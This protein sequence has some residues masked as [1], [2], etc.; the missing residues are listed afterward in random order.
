[1][2]ALG[3]YMLR[4]LAQLLPVA[5]VIVMS[6]YVLLRMAPGDMVDV[7]AGESGAA[8]PEYMAQLRQQFDLDAPGY[9][10]FGR[11]LNNLAHLDLGYSFRNS[12]PVAELIAQRVPATLTLMLVAVAIAALLG[13]TLGAVSAR[14]RGRWLDEVISTL[15]TIGFATPVFWVGLLLI[16]VFS[17]NL[18]WLPSAGMQT[19]GGVDGFWA[20]LLD[21]LRYMALPALSLSFFYLSIY[22]RMTRSAMLEVYGLDFI[23]TARAKGI[24]E[25]R[26][27]VR[28]VLRNALLPLVTITGLQLGSLMGGSIVVETVFSW[29]GLGR[30]AF[31]AVFQ[32]DINLL[33]GIFLCSSFLVIL[34]NLL[35][36]LLYA[37]L[38]PRIEIRS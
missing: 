28:H 5:L 2:P 25:S 26:I 32:R 31:D 14:F 13:I 38:D 12:M 6:S 33:L 19:I 1:M 21:R 18:R 4:R 9:V 16:V 17:I 27:A 29:P 23:R 30:L 36:D 24:S 8:T 34:M 3:K 7:M 20:S 35:V 11:Y 37:V 10:L 22:V 15:S